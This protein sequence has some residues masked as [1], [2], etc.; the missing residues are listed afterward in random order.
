MEQKTTFV[1]KKK[2]DLKKR[3]LC[4]RWAVLEALRK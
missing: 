2:R 3:D 1:K 4:E